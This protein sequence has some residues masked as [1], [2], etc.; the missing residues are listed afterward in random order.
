MLI[1][2]VFHKGH[3]ALEYHHDM[4]FMY[5]DLPLFVTLKPGRKGVFDM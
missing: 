4:C 3:V 5:N 2:P 1:L